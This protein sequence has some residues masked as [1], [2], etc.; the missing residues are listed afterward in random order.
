VAVETFLD[1]KLGFTS[2]SRVIERSMNAHTVERVSSLDDVRRVDA[3]ARDKARALA[4]ELELI[5]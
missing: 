3:W 1:G 2:I 4:A 5:V